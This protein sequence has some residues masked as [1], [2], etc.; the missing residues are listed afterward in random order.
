MATYAV[1][2][3]FIL[4]SNTDRCKKSVI[5][6]GIKI[7]SNLPLELKNVENFKALKRKL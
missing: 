3:S 4:T 6:M 5:N 1:P 7:F 2:T